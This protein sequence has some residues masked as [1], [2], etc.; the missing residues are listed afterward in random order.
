M[1]ELP[2]HLMVTAVMAIIGTVTIEFMNFLL[3]RRTIKSGQVEEHHVRLLLSKTNKYS[4]LKW[5]ILFLFGG[6][7]LIVLGLLPFNAETS[8][9]PWGIE[10]VF[11]GAGFL[12]YYRLIRK[13]DRD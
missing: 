4:A 1:Q 8:P 3:K 10:V 2:A 13:T 9:V 5:G 12:T 6:L 7:G 11:L